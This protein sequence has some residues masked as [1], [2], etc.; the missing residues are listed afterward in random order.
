MPNSNKYQT[1][2]LELTGADRQAAVDI[3]HAAMAGASASG[4]RVT[5]E[6]TPV[7]A[8][9]ENAV[10]L[11]L[12]LDS[13][14]LE[15]AIFGW[16]PDFAMPARR[17]GQQFAALWDADGALAEVVDAMET[18]RDLILLARDKPRRQSLAH[19]LRSEHETRDRICEDLVFE[20]E[21]LANWRGAIPASAVILASG[22][23]R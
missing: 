17:L 2:W 16:A 8:L 10:L 1:N 9:P 4:L 13:R 6:C 12:M 23:A 7:E 22:G 3:I 11:D 5:P 20:S 15:L 19:E 18:M 21:D 14:R